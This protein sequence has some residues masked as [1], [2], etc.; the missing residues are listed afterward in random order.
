MADLLPGVMPLRD[1][2]D[3]AIQILTSDTLA[4]L[5]YN[6]PMDVPAIQTIELEDVEDS[7]EIRAD[8]Q[9]YDSYAVTEKYTL[10]VEEAVISIPVL[11]AMMG[12]SYAV[13]GS[14]TSAEEWNLYLSVANRPYFKLMGLSKYSGGPLAGLN[15]STRITFYKCKLKKFKTMVKQKDWMICSFEMDA[16]PCYFLN[17]ADSNRPFLF[18]LQHNYTSTALPAGSD[19]TAPTLLSVSPTNGA[20]SGSGT[21][22]IVLTYSENIDPSTVTTENFQLIDTASLVAWP[23]TISVA[24]AVVTI[25]PTGSLTNAH[26]YLV[27]DSTQIR[28]MAGNRKAARSASQ[29][30]IA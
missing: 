10:S 21:V 16:I 12:G 23:F 9:I 26:N 28:D 24:G 27:Q 6:Q 20:V 5:A 18:N 17:A 19:V 8:G 7:D 15:T 3:C 2:H 13:T 22:D 1:L 14:G 29:F 25:N 4:G 11:A 30:S